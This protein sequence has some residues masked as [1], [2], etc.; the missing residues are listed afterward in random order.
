MFTDLSP[1]LAGVV[2]AEAA[3]VWVVRPD[4]HVAAVLRDPSPVEL[5]RAL[6]RLLARGLPV[7]V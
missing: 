3:E 6:D 1:A 2:G 5:T 4:A 7:T